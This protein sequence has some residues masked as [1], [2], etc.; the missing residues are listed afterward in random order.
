[1]R[2]AG[3]STFGGSPDGK[4]C[5]AMFYMNEHSARKKKATGMGAPA[6]IH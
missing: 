4:L 5:A 2:S 1:M 6:Q 3:A